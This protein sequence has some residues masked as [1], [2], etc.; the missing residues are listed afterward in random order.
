VFRSN[1]RRLLRWVGWVTGGLVFC[2]LLAY[3]VALGLS[4]RNRYKAEQ[5]IRDLQ[6]LKVGETTAEEVRKLS[7]QHGGRIFH[8][9]KD[10]ADSSFGPTYV[11]GYSSGVVRVGEFVQLLRAPFVRPW[12]VQ[13]NLDLY[14]ERLVRWTLGILVFRSDDFNLSTSVSSEEHVRHAFSEDV[15]YWV[16]EAHVTGPPSQD[17]NVE[18]AANATRVERR[19]AF[20]INMRCLTSLFECKQV[21]ELI[22]SAWQDLPLERRLQYADGREKKVDAYCREALARRK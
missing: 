14:D 4:F 2:L 22:P 21:C 17:V 16:Y 15:S 9:S 19:K 18:L 11:F 5:M 8:V 13:A 1:K 3:V 12:M 7:E 20:D 6:A 10:E